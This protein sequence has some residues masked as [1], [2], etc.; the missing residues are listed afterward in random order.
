MLLYEAFADIPR[1]SEIDAC[2]CCVDS[3]NLCV[4]TSL[5]LRDI[6]ADD[7]GPYAASAFLTVGDVPDYLYFLPR[8]MECSALNEFWWPVPEV[9]GR[10][11]ANTH[12]TEWP[13]PRRVAWH[14]FLSAL[15]A[16]L[17]NQADSGS[18]IDSW[19]CAMARME[20]DLHPFL[21]QIE[22]SPPHVLSFYEANANHLTQLKLA[23][24]FWDLPN[25]GHD[26]ILAWFGSENVGDIV[27]Q[28]YGVIL[29]HD[30]K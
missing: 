1:P 9:T 16:H 24:Q 21:T 19:L 2:P 26:Q 6:S 14:N 4:L 13:A 12:P 7:L 22:Q 11:I 18:E 30:C 20:L 17:L 8:I 28:A 5:P 23:N 25:A 27:F 10:A 3:K 29:Y 15:I